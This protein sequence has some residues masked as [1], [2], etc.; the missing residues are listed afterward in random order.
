MAKAKASTSTVDMK[1]FATAKVS[2]PTIGGIARG[3]ALTKAGVSLILR[4]RR[5]CSL[6]TGAK[7]AGYLGMSIDDLYRIL[8][9]APTR[10]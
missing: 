3:T 10:R 9:M 2:S 5:N 7:I 8:T 6:D 1:R 4:R